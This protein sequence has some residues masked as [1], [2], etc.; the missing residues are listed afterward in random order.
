[1]PDRHNLV[2]I[3]PI[4]EAISIWASHN[5]NADY[6]ALAIN[7]PKFNSADLFVNKK[8]DAKLVHAL[9]MKLLPAMTEVKPDITPSQT[10]NDKIMARDN[11]DDKYVKIVTE[12]FGCQKALVTPIVI[13][14]IGEGILIWAWITTPDDYCSVTIEKA[15]LIT[16]HVA[17]SLKLSLKEKKGQDLNAKLAALLE[18]S[19]AIY[20][21]LN[22][23][24]VLEKA[25]SLSMEI[26][27]A[28]GGSLFIIDKKN[29]LLKPLITVDA[30]HEEEISKITLKVGEGLT[31]LVAKTGIGV[32]SNHSEDD[33]RAVQVPGTPQDPES[34]ISAPLTWSGEVIGVVTLRSESCK[35]FQ[36]ED[37]DI[38]T[39]FARQTA[40]AIENAKLF[41]SLEKAY[42]ELAS[43]Q[44]Q[45]IM[46]E[47]LRALGEMAGGVAHDFN[48][49]LGAILGRTQLLLRDVEDPK[50]VKHLQQIEQMT[51][52]GAKTIQRLQNFTR[53]SSSGRYESIDLIKIVEDAIEMTRPRWK[54]QC[55]RGGIAIDLQFDYKEKLSVMGNPGELAEAFSNLI[56][57][58][59]DALPQGGNISICST[60]QDDKAILKFQDTGVG[61]D[62]VTLKRIFFPFFTTKG[63]QG[64]GM[65]LSVVYGIINRH[66]GEID[67]TSKIGKGTTFTIILPVSQQTSETAIV[68]P[69][70]VQVSKA[71][72]LLVDDDENIRS[73]ISDMLD[74]LGHQVM[75]APCGEDGVKLF[76]KHDFDLVITD[77]GMPGISGWDV[78]RTCKDLKPQV[79]VIMISGWGNQIDEDMISQSRLDGVLAKPFEMNKIKAMLNKVLSEKASQPDI[80]V[81]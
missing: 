35:D 80:K 27:G 42:Q 43:T 70:V 8:A 49:V 48:N 40:D 29:Q 72:V 24:E 33:P 53:V 63:R 10:K 12:T 21:S 71:R 3:R 13:E 19:T 31:G 18:L 7:D 44:E 28:D 74:L 15:A 30:R 51:L 75:A 1:M 61:M 62:E 17:L 25:V 36:Q 73:V 55:Q 32:I 54:D 34:I 58:S 76:Q 52:A 47:K 79:P 41:D 6:F 67:V 57:N 65:G 56:M 16:E 68:Q 37:L 78:T 26:V 59:I 64:T 14:D 45:L 66:R 2:F 69:K 9:E 20:S 77:L 46:T 22:Y 4:F 23:T 81:G 38:L 39:I 5:L 11:A 50:L 60:R